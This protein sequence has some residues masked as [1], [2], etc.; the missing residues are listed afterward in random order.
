MGGGAWASTGTSGGRWYRLW[1]RRHFY[2]HAG[3]RMARP[4]RSEA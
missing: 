3:F 2:Q 4:L 1:F